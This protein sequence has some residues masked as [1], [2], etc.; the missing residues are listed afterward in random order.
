MDYLGVSKESGDDRD[1]TDFVYEGVNEQ[2]EPN[3]IPVDFANP[4][5][6]LGGIKWRRAGTLLGLA[7]DNIEDGSWIRLREVT[8]TYNFSSKIFAKT[9]AISGASISVYG[10]NLLLFTEYKGV[11]PETNL[12]GPSNAQG[13]DYFNMSNTKSYGLALKVTIK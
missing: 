7:E 5:L 8:A 4:A 12:R 10:R 2:G 11:D 1:V 3:T 13:W 6:G 9:K